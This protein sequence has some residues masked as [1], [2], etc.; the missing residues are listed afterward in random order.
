MIYCLK[1]IKLYS[2]TNVAISMRQLIWRISA[3]LMVSL[4][5][6]RIP[7]DKAILSEKDTRHL[8]LKDFESPFTYEEN[9][10]ENTF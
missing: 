4:L 6:W 7:T 5:C 3:S 2:N 10:Y 9:L 1:I 8:L